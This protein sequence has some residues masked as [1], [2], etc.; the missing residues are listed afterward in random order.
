MSCIKELN[1]NEIREL[2]D[3]IYYNEDYRKRKIILW[4]GGKSLKDFEDTVKN[5]R[6]RTCIRYELDTNQ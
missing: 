2:L 5:Y 1:N 3:A 4:F 6:K